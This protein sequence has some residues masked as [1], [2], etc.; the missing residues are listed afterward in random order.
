MLK[1]GSKWFLENNI[2]VAVPSS[3]PHIWGDIGNRGEILYDIEIL[4]ESLSRLG[5][6]E[7]NYYVYNHENREYNYLIYL[8]GGLDNNPIYFSK[9]NIFL[10][11]LYTEIEFI[12][13][14]ISKWNIGDKLYIGNTNSDIENIIISEVL[15]IDLVERKIKLSSEIY[16]DLLDFSENRYRIVSGVGEIIGILQLFNQDI[17]NI[18]NRTLKYGSKLTANVNT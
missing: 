3:I 18:K 7:K 15:E 17:G 6:T 12:N 1:E 16:S 5:Y 9:E 10:N 8:L 4:N 13:F 11:G 2:L 14:D